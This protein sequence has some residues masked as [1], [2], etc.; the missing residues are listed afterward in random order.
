MDANMVRRLLKGGREC[1]VFNRSPKA[2]N[3]LARDKAMGASSLP[4][5]V[6]KLEEPWAVWLMVPAS[7]VDE[8]IVNIAHSLDAGD[9]LIDGGNSYYIDDVR[10]AK[11]LATTQIHYVDVGTNGVFGTGARLPH[12][13]R[14]RAGDNPASR[15]DLQDARARTG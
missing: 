6:R 4:D 8:A 11:E 5:L 9:I 1:L 14:R 10:R 12:D 15:P 7:A 13:D 2:V 3:E